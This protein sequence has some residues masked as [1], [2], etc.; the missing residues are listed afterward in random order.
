[1]EGGVRT[2]KAVING[3][4]AVPFDVPDDAHAPPGAER[5]PVL[6]V[7]MVD[8]S[9]R[10]GIATYTAQLM[11]ALR[12]EGVEVLLAAPAG[13]GHPTAV[14]SGRRWGPDVDRMGRFALYR[15]RLS[16]LGPAAVS[17]LR[18]VARTQPDV[19]HVQT[20]VVPGIDHLVLRVIARRRPVV[21]TAHDPVPQEGGERELADQAKRWRVADA[22]IIHGHEPLPV[23][24]SRAPNTPVHVI[25]VDFR[26]GGPSVPRSEARRRLG[27]SDQPTALL[28]GQLRP[29]KGIGLLAE[30][31]PKVAA[32]LPDARLLL[33]G[34]PYECREIEELEH[35][36][37]VDLRRGF[38]P[39]EQL[40]WWAAAADVLVLPYRY[41]SHSGVLHR[42]LAAGTPVLAS[43]PLA[44]EVLRTGAGRVV[45]LDVE[46]WYENLTE[47]LGGH[48]LPR[49]PVPSGHNTVTGTLEVYREVLAARAPTTRAPTVPAAAPAAPAGRPVRVTYCVEGDVFGGVER[50]TLALLDELDRERFEPTVIGVMA[51]E[52]SQELAAR[53]I[54]SVRLERIRNK[55]D[56]GGWRQVRRAVRRARPEVFH[57]MLSQ[58]YA[59][60]Y[61]LLAAITRRTPAVVVTAH[62]PTPSESRVQESLRKILLRGVDVQV[63]PSEWT[64]AEL[65]RLDQLLPN[66][67]VV[68]N[69]IGTSTPLSR[70]EARRA[71]GIEAGATVIGG[72][73][74]LIPEKRPELV[75]EAAR[76]IPGAV[77]VLLGEGPE[78]DHLRAVAAGVDLRLPGFRTDAVSLLP[79][80][81]VFVHPC[82]T[83]N[84]PLAVLEAMGAGVPV[85]V[86]ATG[87][88]A[89]MVDDG[90][91]GLLAQATPEGMADAV[92]RLVDDPELGQRLAQA[93][94]AAVLAGF[95]ATVMTRR[96]EDLYDGLLQARPAGR[97]GDT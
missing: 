45:P 42:G 9:V 1:V 48:P 69:G 38:V 46:S 27:L 25:P 37:G 86:A 31:W 47:V 66:A 3:S 17:F 36:D 78:A 12:E 23:V 65:A 18:T 15:L 13:H 49:P 33:V 97:A 51:D 14:L 21:I 6:K 93:G 50:H 77:V 63:L 71:L 41:G 85:V 58:S 75:V 28:L 79:A 26:I 52:M 53:H 62:L 30:V 24:E 89:L 59:C 10:G 82:P 83:D 73:M 8:A 68:P 29:Y 70:V 84:Q 32:A 76:S 87:G 7:L 39:E 43:P 11:Q 35:V 92:G 44:E 80:F 40:D 57:A 88:T 22:V 19:V 61:A 91:T 34:E 94:R 54:P 90:R 2:G 4:G 96:L 74:R 64:R 95:S 67:V 56:V 16:E 72:S 60:Q 5:R 55:A 81:D 20:D